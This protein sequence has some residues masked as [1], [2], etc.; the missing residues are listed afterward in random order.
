MTIQIRFPIFVGRKI[1][2]KFQNN[3]LPYISEKYQIKNLKKEVVYVSTKALNGLV[4]SGIWTELKKLRT[5]L[6]NFGSVQIHSETLNHN[7][8][9]S[10]DCKKTNFSSLDSSHRDTS[11]GNRFVSLG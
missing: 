3:L 10:D 2:Q 6:K 4:W 7:I 8:L 11:N 5:E 9:R 1:N